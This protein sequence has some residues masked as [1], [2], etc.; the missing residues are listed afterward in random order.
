MWDRYTNEDL[1]IMAQIKH[2]NRM[3]LD[4]FL[5]ELRYGKV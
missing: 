4:E 2:L 3:E 1:R 5:G